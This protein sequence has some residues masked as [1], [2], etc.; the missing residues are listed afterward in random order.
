MRV[1]ESER[2]P[3]LIDLTHDEAVWLITAFSSVFSEAEDTEAYYRIM[4][5]LE[6]VK[7]Q[8]RTDAD[9]TVDI[10]KRFGLD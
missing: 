1:R 9:K 3:M 8:T 6:S 5:K 4:D 2:C 7:Q 10:L